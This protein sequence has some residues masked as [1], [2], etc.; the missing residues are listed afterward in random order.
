[1]ILEYILKQMDMEQSCSLQVSYLGWKQEIKSLLLHLKK[2]C[3]RC[4][5]GTVP[6]NGRELF[7]HK[8]WVF[9]NSRY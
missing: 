6:M 9:D 7:L 4:I 2:A 8:P 3:R 1:M 5:A